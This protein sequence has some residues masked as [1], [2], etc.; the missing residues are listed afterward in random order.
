MFNFL[1]ASV[2]SVSTLVVSTQV[3]PGL[4]K[5]AVFAVS[6]LAGAL[7]LLEARALRKKN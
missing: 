6:C 3:E 4:A 5:D 2:A 1:I 7:A